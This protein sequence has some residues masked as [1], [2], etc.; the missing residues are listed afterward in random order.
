MTTTSTPRAAVRPISA[1]A[2][3]DFMAR[4]PTI[5]SLAWALPFLVFLAFPIG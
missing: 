5:H 2:L 1:R 3:R 4:H